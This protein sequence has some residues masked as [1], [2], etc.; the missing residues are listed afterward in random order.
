MYRYVKIVNLLVHFDAGRKTSD[1]RTL[2][3]PF[4]TLFESAGLSLNIE[5]NLKLVINIIVLNRYLFF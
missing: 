4:I 1:K 3:V 5:L 2:S